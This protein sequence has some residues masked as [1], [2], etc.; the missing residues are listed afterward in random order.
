MREIKWRKNKVA[1]K[2][3]KAAGGC[4]SSGGKALNSNPSTDKKKKGKL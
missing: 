3:L 1:R 2:A 4:G